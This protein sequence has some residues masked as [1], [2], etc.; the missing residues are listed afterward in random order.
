MIAPDTNV[1]VRVITGDDPAEAAEAAALLRSGP[2]WLAKSVVLETE[3]V[4]RHAYGFE[5]MLVNRALTT[6]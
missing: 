2:L 6:L 4:L 3:W 1:L 5:P